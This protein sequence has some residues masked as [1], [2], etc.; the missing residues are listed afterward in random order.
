MAYMQALVLVSLDGE[1]KYN[2]MTFFFYETF[3]MKF[4]LV[5]FYYCCFAGTL[6][7]EEIPSC[8]QKIVWRKHRRKIN[9]SMGK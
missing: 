5:I 6:I 9:K 1:I 7:K 2:A 4:L 3:S 8:I